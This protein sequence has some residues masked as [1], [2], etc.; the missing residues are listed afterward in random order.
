MKKFVIYLFF[1]MIPVLGAAGQSYRV[2]YSYQYKTDKDSEGYRSDMDMKL[3]ICDGKAVWYSEK[4]FL[5]DSLKHLA[6]D[7]NGNIKNQEIYNRI[8]DIMGTGEGMVT[9]LDFNGRKLSQC[10]KYLWVFINSE[11]DLEMPQ[12]EITDETTISREGYNVRKVV[13]DYMGREWTVWYTEEVPLHYGPW[14]FW[15]LPGLVIE[16]ADSEKLFIFRYMGMEETDNFSRYDT[17]WEWRHIKS[18]NKNDLYFNYSLEVAEKMYTRLQTDPSYNTE[19]TGITDL[20]ATDRSGNLI[21][22]EG[23]IPLIPE[24]YWR[25]R[26]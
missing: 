12:W 3:D 15:G 5:R 24:K 11:A 21:P 4:T 19:I 14:L 16:A 26:K 6:F 9:F 2:W 13:A 8:V 7:E 17:L 20:G 1:L 25:T 18:G 22:S 10:R 23:Y